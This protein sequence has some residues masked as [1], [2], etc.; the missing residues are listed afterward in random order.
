MKFYIGDNL[1]SSIAQEELTFLGKVIFFPGKSK[2]TLFYFKEMFETKLKNIQETKIRNENQLWIYQK[3]FL[4]SIRFLLTIHE[5]E[6][7]DLKQLDALCNMFINKLQQRWRKML[8]LKVKL[9]EVILPFFFFFS[10]LSSFFFPFSFSLFPFFSFSLI[11]FSPFSPLSSFPP[12]SFYH[13]VDGL[14]LT[15]DC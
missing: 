10:F 14:L 4:P 8:H 7:K 2:G 1:I 13:F 12:F 3:Y 11:P 15:V 6:A 5:I 9:K